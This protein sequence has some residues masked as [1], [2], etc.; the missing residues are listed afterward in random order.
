MPSY[1]ELDGEQVNG[2]NVLVGGKQGSGGYRP[3]KSLDVFVRPAEAAAVC[4]EITRIFRD[5]GSRATRT[6][7]RLAFLI[8]DRGLTWFRAE[9]ARRLGRA[10]DRAGPDMRK[11]HHTDHLG[12]NPQKSLGINHPGPGLNSVGLLVP[13]GRI[14]TAQLRGVADLADC[15]GSGDVR[16]TVQ[17]NLV[18]PNVPDNRVG[19][20]TDEPLFK[21][22]PYD[23]SPILRGLVCCTGNDYCHMALIETKGWA[24]AVAREL[25]RQ[26]EGQNI[27]PLTIH[28]SGCP[29]GCGMHQ[30]ATIG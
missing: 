9:L 12:I 23:P 27:Q 11:A 1:R 8:E 17:Q 5:H 15:Y 16:V 28:W 3:A 26:T 21:E 13:V 2:F 6:R 7:A 24:M 19:A 25:E 29:A 20:L 14:T 4:A 18:I 30:V 22:L 10:L